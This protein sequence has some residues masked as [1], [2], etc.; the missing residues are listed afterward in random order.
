MTILS[1]DELIQLIDD[2]VITNVA[3][4]FV[5]SASIDVTLGEE[6]M[7][8]NATNGSIPWMIDLKKRDKPNMRS[9][10][11][12]ADFGYV[13]QPSE[14]ILAHTE[15]KFFFPNNISAQFC[16]KS[17]MARCGLE[18][19]TAGWCDAGWNNS[20]LTLELKNMMRHHSIRIKKGIRIGQMVFHRHT[21]VPEDRS[22]SARGRYNGDN[23]VSGVK[24]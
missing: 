3:R 2:G 19:L 4:D 15:Q 20:V 17:S 22:Y 8:E 12:D 9:Y 10:N 24:A 5:N 16:L 6:I 21:T 13:M 7:I 23:S 14:F 1:H 18:H 11:I